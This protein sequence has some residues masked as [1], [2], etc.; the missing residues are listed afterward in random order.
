MQNSTANAGSADAVEL[1]IIYVVN[2]TIWAQNERNS[3]ATHLSTLLQC[4][5]TLFQCPPAPRTVHLLN[6]KNVRHEATNFLTPTI[7]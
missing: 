7:L 2:L 5:S 3:T 1:P 6:I 4:L